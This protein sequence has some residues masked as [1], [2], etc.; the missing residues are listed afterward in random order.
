MAYSPFDQGRLLRHAALK[1][2]AQ[3][4]GMT[5]GQVAIAWLLAQDG[6]IVI[7][8]TGHVQR[9]EENAA[10]LQRPLSRAQLDELDALF[11][12]PDGPSPLAML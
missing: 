7:P 1:A 9:V 6:V 8:K 3:R 12:P 5:P 10:A 4:H 2:F 11:P